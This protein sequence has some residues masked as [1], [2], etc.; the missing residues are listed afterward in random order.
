MSRTLSERR[1]RVMGLHAAG[2]AKTVNEGDLE[3][4]KEVDDADEVTIYSSKVPADALFNWGAGTDNRNSGRTAFIHADLVDGGGNTITGALEAV[5]TDSRQRDVLARYR[6][7]DLS[8]LSEAATDSRTERPRFPAVG[9]PA[10]EDRH[11]ELRV[12]AD[13][14]SD[15]AVLDTSASDV[16]LYYTDIDA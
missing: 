15:G 2:N 1:A 4:G 16:R 3:D 12:Y 14:D 11:L 8:D 7:G 10:R 9:P 13:S 6:V 5:Y